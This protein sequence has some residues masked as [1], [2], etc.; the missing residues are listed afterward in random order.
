MTCWARCVD[1]LIPYPY[2]P[3]RIRG[4]SKFQKSDLV[5]YR[6]A[7]SAGFDRV[8]VCNGHFVVAGDIGGSS[9]S[10]PGQTVTPLFASSEHTEQP[11]LVSPVISLSCHMIWTVCN[12]TQGAGAGPGR[13]WDDPWLT[14]QTHSSHLSVIT[15]LQKQSHSPLCVGM[16]VHTHARVCKSKNKMKN[17]IRTNQRL[18]D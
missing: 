10:P 12:N 1:A 2:T 3:G 13:K 14:A 8:I 6:R 5:H 4:I 16:C 17:D 9:I 7:R 18:K 15:V 11:Q